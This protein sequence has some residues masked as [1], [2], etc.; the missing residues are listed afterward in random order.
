VKIYRWNLHVKEQSHHLLAEPDRFILVPDFDRFFT[1]ISS[2]YQEFGCA[3]SYQVLFT[4]RHFAP[5]EPHS[6]RFIAE[7]RGAAFMASQLFF[8]V[9]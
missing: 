5:P 9:P 3:V 7:K 8:F 1:G 6:E 2:K 4:V